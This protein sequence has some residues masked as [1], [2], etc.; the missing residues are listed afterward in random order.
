VYRGG[1][2]DKVIEDINKCAL[3]KAKTA[4]LN[5]YNRDQD[6][7]KAISRAIAA[8]VQHNSLYATKISPEKKADIK[9]YWQVFLKSLIEKYKDQ[10]STSTYESDIEALKSSMNERF[11]DSFKKDIHPR[12]KYD[13]GFRISHAQKSISVFLKH[14]WCLGEIARPPQCPVDAIILKKARC[15]NRDIKWCYVNSIEIHNQKISLLQDEVNKNRDG[16]K[17]HLAEWELVRFNT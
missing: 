5:R 4:Y 10:Q 13:Q 7:N 9:K 17:W 12:Y 16:S 6:I 14:L 3:T 1:A 2:L 8:S 11:S 15:K